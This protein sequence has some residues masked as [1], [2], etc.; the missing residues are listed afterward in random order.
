[1]TVAEQLLLPC[2]LVTVRVNVVVALIVPV[3][4]LPPLELEKF[5][6]VPPGAGDH[7]PL[8]GPLFIDHEKTVVPAVCIELGFAEREQV[9]VPAAAAA[10]TVI[11]NPFDTVDPV[12]PSDNVAVKL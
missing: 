4:Q 10:L 9:G 7:V 3:V 6:H 2:A 11:E 5:E 1:M 8:A 12:Q